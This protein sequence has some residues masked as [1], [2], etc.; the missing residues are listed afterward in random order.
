MG[1]APLF[2]SVFGLALALARSFFHQHKCGVRKK[3][4]LW[5]EAM[6]TSGIVPLRTQRR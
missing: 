1:F 6:R 3:N 5:T 2:Q 4:P